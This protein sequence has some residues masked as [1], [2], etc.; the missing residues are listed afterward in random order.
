MKCI[1]KIT[2]VLAFYLY[3]S[4][5]EALSD[6]ENAVN[7][8][9]AFGSPISTLTTETQDKG[10]WFLGQRSVY[11]RGEALSDAKLVSSLGCENQTNYL[12]NY[13]ILSYGV[14]EDLYV[15]A[16]LSVQNTSSIRAAV[17]MNET[18]PLVASNIGDISGINDTY[19]YA[20]WRVS[21]SNNVFKTS[22]AV[23]GGIGVPTGKTNVKMNT[24]QLFSASDQPGS[25]A[26]SPFGGIALSKSCGKVTL[27]TDFLVTLYTEGS[28]K[29]TSGNI[30]NYD[31]AAV[32]NFLQNKHT[33]KGLSYNLSG[34]LE[35]NGEYANKTD[36]N[37]MQVPDSGGN[38]IYLSPGLR[39]DIGG[40]ASVY[41]SY[42]IPITQTVF[43]TTAKSLYN[44][45]SGIS[46]SF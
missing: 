32:Y 35:L 42:A 24:G 9:S 18:L 10:S 12:L 45:I 30:Y 43:P 4:S 21:K 6:H 23:T 41:L 13:L 39:T 8:S 14:T 11:Y 2:F 5:A 15:G 7:L 34:I 19:A 38:T 36:I 17:S 26:F 25:G 22:A 20:V 29:T 31:I 37:G 40:L 3:I 27:S 1:K 16:S 46:F 44:I 33:K 28:Q